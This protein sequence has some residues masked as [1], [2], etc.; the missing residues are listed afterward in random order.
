VIKEEVVNYFK[1][2]FKA[3]ERN[4]INDL[5]RITSLYPR[6]VDEEEAESLFKPVTLEELKSVLENF[7]KE[8]SP[9]PDGWTTEFFTF[10]FDLVGGDLLE[11]VED[12]RRK[13]HLCGGINST[14]LALIPKE[15]KPVSFDDYRPIS[16]CNLIYKVISKVIANQ[17]KPVCQD[18]SLQNNWG[19]YRVEGFRMLLDRPMKACTT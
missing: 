6:M 12:S 7:K 14:F 18:V 3:K 4:N 13:G 10:F 9:G 17:I 11:M 2:F 1:H 16:L 15:N 19:S 5:V 8:R